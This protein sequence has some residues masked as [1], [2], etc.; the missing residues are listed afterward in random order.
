MEAHDVPAFVTEEFMP[1]ED[2]LKEASTVAS[3]TTQVTSRARKGLGV[4][5]WK[6]FSKDAYQSVTHFLDKPRAL[7]D[8]VAQIYRC[9]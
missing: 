5:Y 4:L 2:D 6:A 7:S 3:S 8:V 1:P 9:L